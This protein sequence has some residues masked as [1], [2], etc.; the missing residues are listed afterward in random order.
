MVLLLNI[1][2]RCKE[3]RVMEYNESIVLAYQ[4]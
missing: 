2:A 3:L 4:V 1:M